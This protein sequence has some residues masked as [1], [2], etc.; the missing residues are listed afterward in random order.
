[1]L[2]AGLGDILRC[3]VGN[4]GFGSG[5]NAGAGLSVSLQLRSRNKFGE[6]GTRRRFRILQGL[7]IGDTERGGGR[8]VHEI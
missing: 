5:Y 7:V 1:M 2:T 3:R 6:E 8:G 4:A